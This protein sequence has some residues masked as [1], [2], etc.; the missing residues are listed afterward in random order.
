MKQA[1]FEI[2]GDIAEQFARHIFSEIAAYI[3][4]NPKDYQNFLKQARKGGEE[5]EAMSAH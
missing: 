4:A 5:D 3:E 1:F 2:G